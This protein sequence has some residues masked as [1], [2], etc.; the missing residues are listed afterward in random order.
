MRVALAQH[1]PWP[2]HRATV[3][4]VEDELLV[5]SG[6]PRPVVDPL[7]HWSPGVDVRVGAPRWVEPISWAGRSVDLAFAPLPVRVA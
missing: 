4:S 6:L 2:L 7:V 1:D 5:A 3:A